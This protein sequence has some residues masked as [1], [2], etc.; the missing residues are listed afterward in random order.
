MSVPRPTRFA[1]GLLAVL[2]SGCAQP[3]RVEPVPMS[4]N[5]VANMLADLKSNDAI[6]IWDG[7]S[8]LAMVT[9]VPIW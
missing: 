6:F 4:S 7:T 2:A 1:I 9:K 8:E 3:L 5:E